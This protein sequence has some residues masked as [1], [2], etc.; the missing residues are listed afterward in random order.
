MIEL[1]SL[2]SLSRPLN[3]L[4]I[5]AH[6][7]DI[8]IGCGGAILKLLDRQPTHVDW[9]VLSAGPERRLEAERSAALFLERAHSRGVVVHDFKTS[10]FPYTGDRIKDAFEDLKASCTPDLILTHAR[11]D[12][13]QDHRVVWE[14][15]WNT[16]RD[17]LILEYEIP[18]YDGD[19][20][21]PNVFVRLTQE[22]LARKIDFIF[23]CFGSQTAKHWFTKDTF[24]ALARI[25][26]MESASRYAEGFYCRKMVI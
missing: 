18:K 20:G 1:E 12:L 16:F 24:E 15:T 14:L 3:L 21:S 17:H 4:C 10:Y 26:G 11:D 7:D 2:K 25:R 19:L 8:E 22:Q 23:R 6:S 13:H 5:G 9:I